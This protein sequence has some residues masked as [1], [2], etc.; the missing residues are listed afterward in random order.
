L[1][2]L[3]IFVFDQLIGRTLKHFYFTSTTGVNYQT[4]YSMDSTKADIII[5][6]SS[7]A[8]HHY[9]PKLIEDRLGMS[10]FNTGRDGNFLLYNYGVFNAIIKRYT[11]KI[12]I[13]DINPEEM[14]FRQSSYDGLATLLPY[15]KENPE[16]DKVIALK[17]DFERVKLLSCIYPYNSSLLNLALGNFSKKALMID[18]LKGYLPLYGS[19]IAKANDQKKKEIITVIDHNKTDALTQLCLQ[20]KKL[21]IKLFVVSS[22][23]YASTDQ[24]EVL[25]IIKKITEDNHAEFLDYQND[26]IFI[27]N[28]SYFKDAAHLNNNG[29]SIFTNM[30]IKQLDRELNYNKLTT[31]YYPL[32]ADRGSEL[33]VKD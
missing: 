6:G 12:I 13:L 32:Q 3:I 16:I 15:Y 33:S 27:N 5:L 11:P 21:G 18:T 26:S 28:P 4:T 7:R 19:N 23:R 1:F 17:S 9:I 30:I 10:C 8:S 25:K 24:S 29:A 14:I 31:K 20:C 2:V 22:P